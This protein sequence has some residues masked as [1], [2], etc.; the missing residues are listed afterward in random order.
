MKD[1]LWLIRNTLRNTFRKKSSWIIYFALPLA[2]VIL[3]ML[4]YGNTSGADLRVGIVN[5]DG[6]RP[7]AADAIRF[8]ED[9]NHVKVTM[10]DE[11]AL[12]KEIAAGNLDSGIVFGAG[13][14]AAVREGRQ[15]DIRI[16]SAKGAQV[17]AYVKAMLDGYVGN[18][19]AIGQA[20]KGD[21]AKFDAV[22]AEYMKNG[23]KMDSDSLKDT[24]NVKSMT[25]Q[26]IGFLLMFMMFSASNLAELI[27]KEKENRTF[28]RLLA[29][30]VSARMYVLSNVL[31][32]AFIL[33]L[34][35]VFMLAV[36]RF[37]FNIDSGVPFVVL[38]VSLFLFSLAAI[39]LSLLLVAFSKNSRSAGA[40]QT[41]II[42]PTCLL[43]GCTFPPEIM[44]DIIQKI[45]SFL[46]QSWLLNT[47]T[48]LQ[49][50]RTF[51]SLYL[52][53]AILV[54]FAAAFSLIAV[55]RFSRN[56]DVRQFI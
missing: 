31:V 51:G 56:N 14:E 7:V 55:Y 46:P 50:G 42:T 26:S 36:M 15:P 13:Y 41:L 53:L 8:V 25:Y 34:Q 21:P 3:S 23:F 5:L 12:N 37:V 52:N 1:M 39:G 22:Y 43:S 48:E 18:V 47:V 6:D 49:A 35:I 40:L 54:G 16:V 45:A 19:A 17:T 10:T 28:L 30:P 33:L 27:L 38:L 29:S 20:A 11:A 24:S 32:T 4:I 2:G 44:P 9:L